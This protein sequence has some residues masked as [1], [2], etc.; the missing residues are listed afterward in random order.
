MQQAAFELDYVDPHTC[1]MV[2]WRPYSVEELD[3]LAAAPFVV[4]DFETKALTPFDKPLTLLAREIKRGMDAT[5]EARVLSVLYPSKD[6]ITVKAWDLVK[7]SKPQQQHLM[8][9]AFDSKV[10]IGH[11]LGFDG[12][13]ATHINPNI[14]PKLALDT[15]LMA[16]VLLPEQPIL[17]A[18]MANDENEDDELRQAAIDVFMKGR[19]GWSLADLVLSTKKII[20]DKGFQGPRNWCEPFLSQQAYNYATGDVKETYDLACHLLGVQHDENLLEAY[21]RVKKEKPALALIEPQVWDVVIMRVQGLPWSVKAAELY[22][23]AQEDKVLDLTNKL[24]EMEPTLEPFR[25]TIQDMGE[26]I[27]ANL[28]EAL[29]RCFESRGLVLDVT[30]KTGS[31]KIGEK[32]LRRVKAQVTPGAAELFDCW[33]GIQKAKKTAQMALEVSSFANR[34]PDGRLHPATG[35]GPATGRLKSSLP[36]CQQFPRDQLFRNCVEAREGYSIIAS[37]YSALDMRVGAALAVRAQV[38]IHEAYIGIRQCD[39]AV[40][41][42]IKAVMEKR[43]SVEAAEKAYLEALA[44]FNEHKKHRET[45]SDRKKYWE[46]YRVKAQRTLLGR[47]TKCLAIVRRNAE[48]AG[49][50]TWSSLRDAF[51]IPGMDIHTWTALSMTGR[52]PAEL[53]KG[54]SGEETVKELKRWKKELGDVRQTGKVGNLSLLYA[55]Q[56][57]GLVDAAAKNYNIHWEFEVAD[58]VRKDWFA[59]YVEVDLWHC[60]TELNPATT[61]YIPDPEKGGQFGRKVAYASQTLGGRTIY[62]LGLNAA[63]AFEDQSTG[64]DIL[65]RVMHVLRTQYPDI[66]ATVAN[67]VHDEMVFEVPDN[68]VEEYLPLITQVMN[69]AANHFMAPYGVKGECSPAVGKV[70]LKD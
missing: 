61:V 22:A 1:E 8:K 32:D 29:S 45:T 37:D 41:K 2:D 15:M 52:D 68:K 51:D 63:L 60:W 4:A 49:T 25:L 20:V 56:T 57:A 42:C 43:F 40:M 69:D 50:S 33:I 12:G 55:M 47:F 70:W 27:S 5:C 7:L 10:V 3:E 6:G 30:L 14:Q 28:K 54:L 65:G 46:A 35:H 23:R 11:N 9:A 21:E 18:E 58:K 48:K 24:I 17:L 36:N 31:A 64:A 67:Q 38:Q 66:F 19:S 59:S 62:A 16:R 13:W 44:D 53:F 34:S 26:G 39:Q